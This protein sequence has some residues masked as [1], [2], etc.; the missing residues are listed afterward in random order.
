L[1]LQK[2]LALLA[3]ITFP[4][5]AVISTFSRKNTGG[6]VIFEPIFMIF[7]VVGETLVGVFLLIGLLADHRFM[8]GVETYAGVKLA[9][10][11]PILIVALY[12]ILEQGEGSFF[13]RIKTFLQSKITMALVAAGMFALL[14]LGI[15]VARSGNFVLPVPMF[16]KYF[17]NFL[18]AILFIRPRTKEFL[19]GYPLLALSALLVLK[20]QRRWLWVLAAIGTIAPISLFNTFCH[21]HTPV[22]ISFVRSI[23]GLALGIII[24]TIVVLIANKFIK[25]KV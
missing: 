16:E 17:R 20:G 21:I 18:E 2:G 3:G 6:S 22:L 14:A 9:L 23:N 7:N 5:L 25:E 10:I 11:L 19:V 8:L 13:N 1:L 24:G 4:S 12:F 15:F